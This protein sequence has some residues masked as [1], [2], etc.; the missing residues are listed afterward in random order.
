VPTYEPVMLTEAELA[1]TEVDFAAHCVA[2][3]KAVPHEQLA[4]NGY[5]WYADGEAERVLA[6]SDCERCK[7]TARESLDG[8]A[9][10]MLSGP[11]HALG[12]PK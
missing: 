1:M 10:R 3:W 8:T 5:I 6:T 12:V 4:H 9:R 2:K 7:V 11:V